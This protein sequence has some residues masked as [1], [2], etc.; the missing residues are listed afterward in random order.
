[1]PS[2]LLRA[3]VQKHEPREHFEPS[4]PPMADGTNVRPLLMRILER[5][6]AAEHLAR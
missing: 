3:L 6:A 5:P 1:M 2:L 4:N